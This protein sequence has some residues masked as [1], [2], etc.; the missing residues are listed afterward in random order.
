MNVRSDR[1]AVLLHLLDQTGKRSSA[2]NGNIANVNTPGFK[3][4]EVSFE[5]AMR[6]TLERGGSVLQVQAE[7]TVDEL[8]PGRIDGNNVDLEREVALKEQ[9]GVLYDAYLTLL[10][11]HY[12]ML[13]AAVQSGR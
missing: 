12:R 7:E 5:Q 2:L 1:E 8:T 13:D 4:R 10:E 11:S 6:R 9:N 3:R